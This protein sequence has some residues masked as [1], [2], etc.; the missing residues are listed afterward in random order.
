MYG[1]V[2]RFSMV[3]AELVV[4]RSLTGRAHGKRSSETIMKKPLH[5]AEVGQRPARRPQVANRIA[6]DLKGSGDA[7][8]ELDEMPPRTRFDDQEI[9]PVDVPPGVGEPHAGVGDESS[10]PFDVSEWEL[11]LVIERRGLVQQLRPALQV[12]LVDRQQPF[13]ARLVDLDHFGE[14]V[15]TTPRPGHRRTSLDDGRQ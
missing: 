2:H 14:V 1:D 8:A 15:A 4:N 12:G 5:R 3:E 9:R 6:T 11:A 13:K 7:A 10:R